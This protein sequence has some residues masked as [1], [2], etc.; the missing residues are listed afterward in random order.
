LG[1]DR[2]NS[3]GRLPSFWRITD[4]RWPHGC[5]ATGPA[6]DQ[7][8]WRDRIEDQEDNRQQITKHI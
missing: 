7:E 8:E 4:G 2:E 5:S 3:S 6:M 1:E